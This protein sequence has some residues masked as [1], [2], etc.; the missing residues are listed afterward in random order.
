MNYYDKY[1]KYKNKYLN[2]KSLINKTQT[3]GD[4]PLLN[5]DLRINFFT[6]EHGEKVDQF[7]NPIYGLILT[8]SGYIINNYWLAKNNLISTE[9]SALIKK[10]SKNIPGSVQPTN[11]IMK[12]KPIDFGRFIAIKYINLDLNFVF[13]NN[14]ANNINFNNI[15]REYRLSDG[16]ISVDDK[17]TLSC[18]IEVFKKYFKVGDYDEK[19]YFHIILY[20]LYWNT[21]NYSGILEYYSGVNEIFNMMNK[22]L[23]AEKQYRIIDTI[24]KTISTGNFESTIIKITQTEF[25]VFNQEWPKTICKTSAIQTYPD[26]G[27][28]TVRN[29]IN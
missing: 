17:N 7:L 23:K 12:L 22:Y 14:K 16:I 19:I 11:P 4:K 9:E 24:D 3:G 28:T 26:C 1:S 2:L 8:E 29:L 6:E 25:K 5:P 20:C 27:E 18:Y 13:T 10:I 21:N 15:K